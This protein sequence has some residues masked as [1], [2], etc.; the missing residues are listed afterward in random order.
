[1]T[2]A[3]SSLAAWC[4]LLDELLDV[5]GVGVAVVDRALR[6][7]WANASL[8]TLLGLEPGTSPGR[9]AVELL[10]EQW[11]SVEAALW[12]SFT[13]PEASPRTRLGVTRGP[14]VE[15]RTQTQALAL[16]T[17]PWRDA[18]GVVSAVVVVVR[19]RASLSDA[20]RSWGDAERRYR[21]LAE[22]TTEVVTILDDGGVIR[23]IS[24]SVRTVLGYDPDELVGRRRMPVVD[25]E[26]QRKLVASHRASEAGRAVVSCV[27][28]RRAD[29]RTI[30]ME[31]STR[32]LEGEDGT[33]A[34]FHVSSRD[35]TARVRAQTLVEVSA[36]IDRVLLDRPDVD[37]CLRV[38]V[39]GLAELLDCAAAVVWM[40]GPDRRLTMSAAAGPA[41]ET[42]MT[43]GLPL[44]VDAAADEH[45]AALAART[46]DDQ[47]V[48][49]VTTVGPPAWRATARDAH[50]GA[51][52][53]VPVTDP[54]A[55]V[56][57]VLG[58]LTP[59]A[60]PVDRE[61]AQRVA[62][63]AQR[64]ALARRLAADRVA[65]EAQGAALAEANQQLEQRVAE[66]TADLDA[67]L[68]ELESFS[69]S[70]SHDLRAP[71]RSMG[72]YLEMVAV[73]QAE[74]LDE[75]GRE[76]LA[77]IGRTV[78]QLTDMVDALLELASVTGRD[79]DRVPV[80][81]GAQAREIGADLA[82]AHPDRRVELVVPDAV[83]EAHADPRLTRVLLTNLLSNAWKFTAGLPAARV[84]LGVDEGGGTPVFT[85]ADNGVGFDPT[86]AHRL[87]VAFQRL[88]RSDDFPGTGVGLATVARICRRHG[89]RVWAEGRPGAG[90]RFSFTLGPDEPA[91]G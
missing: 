88:H 43:A 15:G 20:G 7:V 64:L 19:P 67:A 55:A 26:G 68:A 8:D 77:V 44:A 27:R 70:V 3:A 39:D 74:H 57:G 72:S 81:L 13:A 21:L 76:D 46:G 22:Q 50:L 14:R 23:Y 85:V 17:R 89:G 56:I 28:V 2:P 79:L 63:I 10:E 87:F 11:P 30:W 69:Y 40:V 35:V 82:R 65:L 6:C 18:E 9:S 48:A 38:A 86:Q 36:A 62:A 49:D 52:V 59:A 16:E 66:R 54:D 1:M 29:G 45:P 71:L 32:R 73:D 61:T 83:P 4:G 24:P 75:H 5:T 51:G 80:D 33:G 91:A 12:H 37:L 58:F 47:V 25:R 42:L 31:N 78:G 84:E 34:S 41:A 60:T 53:W 90:A